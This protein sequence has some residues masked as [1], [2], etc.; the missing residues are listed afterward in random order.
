VVEAPQLLA[1]RQQIA[2]AFVAKGGKPSAFNAAN[3]H[4]HITVGFTSADIQEE[5]GLVKDAKSIPNPLGLIV[6]PK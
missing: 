5:Q 6:D 1:L 4:P 3:Y 2:A